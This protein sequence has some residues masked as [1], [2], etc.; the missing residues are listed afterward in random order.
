M[1]RTRESLKEANSSIAPSGE[2]H[3]ASGVDRISSGTRRTDSVRDSGIIK[4]A[5]TGGSGIHCSENLRKFTKE[6]SSKQLQN[7]FEKQ[8]PVFYA[9]LLKCLY[10]VHIKRVQYKHFYLK[11]TILRHSCVSF[12][13]KPLQQ[14]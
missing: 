14:V 7:N 11:V 9:Y 1:V 10:I 5:V 8:T 12:V 4:D 2:G 6:L 3:T 13:G